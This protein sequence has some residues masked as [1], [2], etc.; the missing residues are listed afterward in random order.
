M[1]IGNSPATAIVAYR[2][3][4]RAVPREAIQPVMSAHPSELKNTAHR[5]HRHVH[6]MG[7]PGTIVDLV[8]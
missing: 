1:M 5:Q 6:V 3:H 4:M 2:G 8:A 7:M